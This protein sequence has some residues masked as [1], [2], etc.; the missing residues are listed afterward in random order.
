MST[1]IDNSSTVASFGEL[2]S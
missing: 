2:I 1:V